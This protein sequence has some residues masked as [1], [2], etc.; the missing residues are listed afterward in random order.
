MDGGW[1]EGYWE[2]WTR[3]AMGMKPSPW[4][5]CRLIS[6]MLEFIVGDKSEKKNPLRWDKVVL[7][8]PGDPNYR[9][10]MP[11]VYKWNEVLQSI[12]CDIKV[13]VDDCR[14]I[15]PTMEDTIRATHRL[16]SRMSYLGIQDATR[17]R[18]RITQRPG[19]WTGSIVQD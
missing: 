4:V 12:A 18:R 13:F 10:D 7:N 15:G 6:W 5:T 3:M 19:E 1:K 14:I 16:E 8:L 17:K 11:R 2:S 9:P